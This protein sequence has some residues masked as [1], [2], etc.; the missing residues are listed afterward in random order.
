MSDDNKPSQPPIGQ[1]FARVY[2]ER[3]NAKK[4]LTERFRFRIAT[5]AAK[6]FADERGR[7]ADLLET[8]LGTAVPRIGGYGPTLK[9]YFLQAEP[10]MC[11]ML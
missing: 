8:E 9:S 5:Y 11:S 1:P 7:L 2:L 10:R 4:E 3:G 6:N